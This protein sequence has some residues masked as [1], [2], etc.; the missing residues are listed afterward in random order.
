MAISLPLLEHPWMRPCCPSLRPRRRRPAR[1]RRPRHRRRLHRPVLG[2]TISPRHPHRAHP[3]PRAGLRLAHFLPVLGER[4]GR[5][6]ASGALLILA[7]IALTEFLPSPSSPPA[8]KASRSPAKLPPRREL[9]ASKRR[10]KSETTASHLLRLALVVARSAH[11]S[12]F[13]DSSLLAFLRS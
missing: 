1:H 9:K 12:P 11:H 2:A 6:G 13:P 10:A 5:R 4:L 7:G 8:T 3:R